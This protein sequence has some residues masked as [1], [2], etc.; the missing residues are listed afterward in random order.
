L[1]LPKGWVYVPEEVRVE[2]KAEVV[3]P[4]QYQMLDTVMDA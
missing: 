1:P 2:V 4:A 3:D